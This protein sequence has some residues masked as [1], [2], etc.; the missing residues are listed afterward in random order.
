M[1]DWKNLTLEQKKDIQAYREKARIPW[2]SP[3]HYDTNDNTYMINACNF[4]HVSI[5]GQSR[6]RMALFEHTLLSILDKHCS[7]I[8]AWCVLPNHYHCII[9]TNDLQYTIFGLG[10]MHGRLSRAWNLE[11]NTLG[12]KCWYRCFDRIIRSERQLYLSVNYVHYNPIK[13]GYVEK[14]PDWAFSSSDDYVSQL[15]REK[16]VSIWKKYPVDKMELEWE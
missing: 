5:I 12:R 6:E 1:L 8:Y 7:R 11:D 15:G 10:Q 2:H 13:H 16:A 3:P 4:N 14:M 9:E